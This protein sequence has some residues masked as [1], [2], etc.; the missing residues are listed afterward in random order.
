MGGP[1]CTV[2]SCSQRWRCFFPL[3]H[4]SV[5]PPH[6]GRL[7][8]RSAVSMSMLVWMAWIC[9]RRSPTKQGLFRPML[10]GWRSSF[11]WYL[12][13]MM[14][15]QWWLFVLRI[16]GLHIVLLADRL[17]RFL[18]FLNLSRRSWSC[19]AAKRMIKLIRTHNT[20]F[21][22][23]VRYS[24]ADHASCPTSFSK[25]YYHTE[26]PTSCHFERW[27]WTMNDHQSICIPTTSS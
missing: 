4:L 23:T 17:V 16:W 2:P 5:V 12:A 8:W 22:R 19:A 3:H 24:N 10:P 25:K 11:P 14:E 15:G 20:K 13:M 18:K 26:F 1:L 7:L 21:L 6:D 27:T 9:S